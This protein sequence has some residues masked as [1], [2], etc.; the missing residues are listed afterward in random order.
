MTHVTR[1]KDR[2]R[3]DVQE[4]AHLGD[5]VDDTVDDLI[6]E[7]LEDDRIVLNLE[8]SL[9]CTRHDNARADV[10]DGENRDDVAKATE[11][12][13]KRSAP[14]RRSGR[15]RRREEDDGRVERDQKRS[16]SHFI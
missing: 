8:L 7:G 6:L 10:G 9:P 16:C 11:A 15:R 2:E 4:D 13:G 5:V 12:W 3:A 14:R 1:D